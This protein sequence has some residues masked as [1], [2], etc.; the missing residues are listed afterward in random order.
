MSEI[1][2]LIF[3]C[4]AIIIPRLKLYKYWELMNRKEKQPIRPVAVTL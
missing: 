4:T 3:A 1:E 2:S